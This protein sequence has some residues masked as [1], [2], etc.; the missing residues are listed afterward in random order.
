MEGQIKY[1][2]G[3]SKDQVDFLQ[4]HKVHPRYIFDGAGLSKKEY[5]DIMKEL[6]KGII[7]NVSPCKEKGH[8]MRTRA[9]HCCQCNTT[10]LA[11]QQRN[12][13]AGVVYIAGSISGQVIKIGY[14][15]AIEVRSESLNRTR[16]AGYKDWEIIYAISSIDAG[17]IETKANVL[18]QKYELSIPYTHDGHWQDSFETFKCSLT[19]ATELI[20]GVCLTNKY[21]FKEI[22][23]KG[24]SSKYGF[25]N[26]VKPVSTTL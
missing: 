19:T 25:R 17:R 22:L 4:K 8:T 11:F 23:N 7:F 14:T 10:R 20:T 15:K 3:L 18:L 16:Y 2:S 12:D 13:S 1:Q 24:Y 9:G 26:I 6:N 5:H 21:T